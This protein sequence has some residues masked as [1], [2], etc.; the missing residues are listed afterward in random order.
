MIVLSAILTYDKSYGCYA[1]KKDRGDPTLRE[2]N[3]RS[4]RPI[5]NNWISRKRK[6]T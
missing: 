4:V 5:I 3:N 6:I 1:K 2:V